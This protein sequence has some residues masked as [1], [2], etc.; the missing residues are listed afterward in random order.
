MI[1]C[2]GCSKTGTHVL[3]NICL[4]IDKHQ[5]GGTVVKRK[6]KSKFIMKGKAKLERLF[7]F[8]NQN[9]V[10][11][12]ISYSDQLELAMAR[13]KHLLMI[14][15]PRDV[16]IS[17][18]RHR[19]KEDETMVESKEL[20]IS[21]I[22]NGMFGSSVP[23]FYSG[24]LGWLEGHNVYVIKFEDVVDKNIDFSE[25]AFYLKEDVDRFKY[26]SILGNSATYT[27]SYSKWRDW[28]DSDVQRA[29]LKSGGSD[30]ERG[31]SEYYA[32]DCFS[33]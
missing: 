10:H 33:F 12:H 2:N 31:L 20:L 9:F 29:W 25:L 11:C 3:T 6:P 21:L 22:E 7:S 28:W 32:K 14:R 16:A 23:D 18:M 15:N 30:I 19:I 4:S 8:S 26:E 27:G 1:F 17:W 13:H 5:I 24:F